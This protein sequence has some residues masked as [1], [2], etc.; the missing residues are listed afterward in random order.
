MLAS[1]RRALLAAQYQH[2]TPTSTLSTYSQT[3][4]SSGWSLAH[5]TKHENNRMD[6]KFHRLF[7][8]ADASKSGQFAS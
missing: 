1:L 3:H 5:N 7:D 6:S 4:C 2:V 8:L